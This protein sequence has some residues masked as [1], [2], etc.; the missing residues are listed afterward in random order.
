VTWSIWSPLLIVGLVNSLGVDSAVIV[1][2]DRGARV[3]W[4]SALLR[5]DIFQET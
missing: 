1:G 2:H 5:P 4:H 3:A